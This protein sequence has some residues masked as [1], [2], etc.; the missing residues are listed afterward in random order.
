MASS[1][2]VSLDRQAGPVPWRLSQVVW[3]D[4]GRQQ[5]WGSVVGSVVAIVV[6]AIVGAVRS[7]N[8][9]P[10]SVTDSSIAYPDL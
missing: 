4:V 8:T 3:R 10:F 6:L 9:A 7:L 2:S 1:S 5:D